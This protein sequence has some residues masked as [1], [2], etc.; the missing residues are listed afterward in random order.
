MLKDNVA[1]LREDEEARISQYAHSE[2]P[3]SG[4][5]TCCCYRITSTL[6]AVIS[7]F[8]E[9]EGARIVRLVFPQAFTGIHSNCLVLGWGR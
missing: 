6:Q 4:A 5:L 8:R 7:A 1:E 9:G 3:R 2:H